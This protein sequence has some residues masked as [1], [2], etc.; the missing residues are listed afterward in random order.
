[1]NT[2]LD[3]TAEDGRMDGRM[4]GGMDEGS[5]HSGWKHFCFYALLAAKHLLRNQ[6]QRRELGWSLRRDVRFEQSFQ[7]YDEGLGTSRISKWTL[8]GFDT[9]HQWAGQGQSL[10]RAQC[11]LL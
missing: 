4:D 5:N 2:L 8:S 6:V 3:C 9:R 10:V 1:M 11:W 7:I